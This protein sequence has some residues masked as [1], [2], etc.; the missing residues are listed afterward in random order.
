MQFA[1]LG[2]AAWTAASGGV[3]RGY[4]TFNSEI[5]SGKWSTVE[6]T[7]KLSDAKKI[8][9]AASRTSNTGANVSFSI[10][11]KGVVL[12]EI[13][14]AEIVGDGLTSTADGSSGDVQEFDFGTK[15]ANKTVLISM[16]VKGDLTNVPSTA[17]VGFSAFADA[18]KSTFLQYI[19]MDKADMGASNWVETA[20]AV[21]LN[22]SGKVYSLL[23]VISV[24]V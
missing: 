10:L 4:Y 16:K 22:N 11:I 14:G 13:D 5:R 20:F 7:V 15:Y 23:F 9:L 2:L 24:V 6:I 1:E 21:T 3:H 19:T 12:Q 18:D 8:Y 17:A